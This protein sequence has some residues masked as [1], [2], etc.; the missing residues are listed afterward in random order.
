MGLQMLNQLM[1]DQ[2]D[3]LDDLLLYMP[4]VQATRPGERPGYTVHGKLF[5]LV[6]GQ[7]LSV[8]LPAQRVRQLIA[9]GG[10]FSSARP[11]PGKNG[12]EWLCI[13]RQMTQDYGQIIGLFEEAIYYN[14]S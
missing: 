11:A 2:N 6:T 10:P 8:R 3:V 14:V 5:C 9:S 7:G 4:G 13:D 1:I 12:T